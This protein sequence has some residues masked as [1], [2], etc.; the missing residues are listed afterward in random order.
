MSIRDNGS[1]FDPQKPRAGRGLKS[2]YYR[3]TE[4]CGDL[5]IE[6]ALGCSTL[7]G[8]SLAL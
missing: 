1:G 5:R 3:A 6:S 8:L 7:I 4:L 2:L